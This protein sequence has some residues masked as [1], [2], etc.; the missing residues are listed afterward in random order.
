MDSGSKAVQD[1]RLREEVREALQLTRSQPKFFPGDNTPTENRTPFRYP[2]TEKDL[3]SYLILE[4]PPFGLTATV[5]RGEDNQIK[6]EANDHA[7]DIKD[8]ISDPL[9]TLPEGYRVYGYILATTRS[10]LHEFEF[11]PYDVYVPARGG[12]LPYQE[13]K[14]YIE[15]YY[16]PLKFAKCL[17][18]GEK[19]KVY[20][21]IESNLKY[22]RTLYGVEGDLR[23]RVSGVT[24]RDSHGQFREYHPNQSYYSKIDVPQ[25]A[26]H[27][28]S[29]VHVNI[30]KY[31]GT[32]ISTSPSTAEEGT[33]FELIMEH[34]HASIDKEIA[35]SKK[36]ISSIP[37]FVSS[38]L[39]E[40]EEMY[41][42]ICDSE[43][44]SEGDRTIT[45]E[46]L[47]EREVLKVI[48]NYWVNMDVV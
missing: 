10:N 40:Y 18:H 35:S 17:A 3:N 48:D 15:A 26:A 6:V 46:I 16:P 12:L 31:R 45:P 4:V 27:E 30:T 41:D 25:S 37:V 21:W 36:N 1:A 23:S 34:I 5:Y 47:V 9:A 13:A 38:S 44:M 22:A 7:S 32:K 33:T 28:T 11:I 19:S 43:T 2:T 8:V 14:E 24:V 29:A 20:H 39:K 42:D